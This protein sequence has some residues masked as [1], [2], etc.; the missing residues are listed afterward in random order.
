M[1]QLLDWWMVICWEAGDFWQ[2][3]NLEQFEAGNSVPFI[4]EKQATGPTVYLWGP[5]LWPDFLQL[6]KVLSGAWGNW[7]CQ[8]TM[9]GVIP[10]DHSTVQQGL[11]F[12]RLSEIGLPG[13]CWQADYGWF[14]LFIETEIGKKRKK[15]FCP[16]LKCSRGGPGWRYKF[17]N[18]LSWKVMELD[19]IIWEWV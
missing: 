5:R 4:Q 15:N 16:G 19:E 10:G 3:W 8:C 13:W 11:S 12:S 17:G 9:D 14:K 7:K 2:V 6:F 1:C 18:N